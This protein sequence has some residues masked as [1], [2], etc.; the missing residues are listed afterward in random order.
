MS[1]R[2]I[3]VAESLTRFV[4]ESV[5]FPVAVVVSPASRIYLFLF[6]RITFIHYAT[7]QCFTVHR[8]YTHYYNTRG[9][10]MGFPRTNL[11]KCVAREESTGSQANENGKNQALSPAPLRIGWHLQGLRRN[12]LHTPCRMTPTRPPRTSF[13]F[14][15]G[16]RQVFR[17]LLRRRFGCAPDLFA[18]PSCLSVGV[19]RKPNNLVVEC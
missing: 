5:S 11:V 8:L 10:T 13:A 7:K 17:P 1:S 15:L 6:I 19:H 18:T 3:A 16:D 12:K 9:R 2:V 4:I 14:E